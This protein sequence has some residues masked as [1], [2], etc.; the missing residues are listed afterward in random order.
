MTPIHLAVVKGSLEMVALLIDKGAD[1]NAMAK[2]D[3]TP[4]LIANQE[5][6]DEI[7]DLLFENGG[8]EAE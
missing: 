8:R 6:K 4:L 3:I 2:E 5:G 7:F 1:L